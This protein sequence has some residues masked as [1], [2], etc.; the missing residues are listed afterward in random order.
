MND[1]ALVPVEVRSLPHGAKLYHIRNNSRLTRIQAVMRT[2]SI[3]EGA[4]A[5]CGLSH[6]LEHMLFQGCKRHPG[7]SASDKIHALGGDCNAYTTFDHTAYYVEVP[8]EKFAEAADVITSMVAEPTFPE[9]K[10]NSEKKV[11][12][13]E[14]DM[15]AN[16]PNQVLI[17]NLWQELF[18]DHP[19]RF[20]I[21]GYG[22]KIAQVTRS[23]MVNYYQRRY[24][25][26]RSYWIVTGE[27]DTDTVQNVLTEKL[28]NFA[29]GNLQDIVMQ[30]LPEQS[31]AIHTTAV[32]P[33]PLTRIVCGVRTPQASHCDAAALDLAAGI[34]GG[35]DSSLLPAELVYRRELAL[36]LSSEFDA[37]TFAG[38][39]GISAAC[40]PRKQKQLKSSI[41]AMLEKI[42]HTGITAE[43]LK[44]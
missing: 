22:D 36:M 26:M 30:P 27:L 3:H 9:E 8:V 28:S 11:I 44:R 41:A 34:L 12:E 38:V 32:F 24:G 23:D 31:F 13:R 14:A 43:A 5:G 25:A 16:R 40:E 33:D 10:F 42:R 19:A 35:S 4:D 37:M 15:I 7:N 17:Q 18:P 1:R 21:I 2:G 20:P 6:F 39:M 29:R